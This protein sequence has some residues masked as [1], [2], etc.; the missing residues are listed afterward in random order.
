MREAD[1]FPALTAPRLPGS[2]P[3]RAKSGATLRY[4]DSAASTLVP[5]PVIEAA[6]AVWQQG[7][8]GA[9]RGVHARARTAEQVIEQSRAQ[10]LAFVGATTPG[11]MHAQYTIVFRPSITEALNMLAR[12]LCESLRPGDEVLVTEL[13]HHANLLSW[14]LAVTARGGRVVVAPVTPAGELTIAAIQARLSMRTKFVALPHVANTTGAIVD[15]RSI[16]DCTRPF[17]AKV[18]VDGA[19]APR[20][21]HVNVPSLGADAYVFGSHK[22]HGPN[23][24]AAIVAT[25]EFFAELP[26]HWGGGHM[27][28]TVTITDRSIENLHL[29]SIPARHEAGSINIEA[30]AGFGAAANYLIEA[31]KRSSVSR[32][33]ELASLLRQELASVPS[34]H[35][36]QHPGE[37]TVQPNYVGIVSFHVSNVD[38]NELAALLDQD[39]L[40]VRAGL[41]CAQPFFQRVDAPAGIVRATIATHNDSDEVMALAKAVRIAVDFLR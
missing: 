27:L 8:G 41:L 9:Y 3:K 15:V 39:G 13:D 38:P 4:F 17:G 34:L 19:Q 28:E 22:M 1:L 18:V 23:G 2:E 40:A 29:A 21:L 37:P 30:I 35:L 16:V 7:L 6:T 24:A 10:L 11:D 25:E 26:P 20:H 5:T 36:L 32:E 14:H 12:T 31:R 33:N